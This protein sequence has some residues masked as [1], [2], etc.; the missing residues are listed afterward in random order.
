MKKVLIGL[1]VSILLLP[2]LTGCWSKTEL[3]DL[4][5][6]VA[7]G[8]DKNEKG[9]FVVSV[10]IINPSETVTSQNA[11]GG[12]DT[13]VTTYTS[14]GKILF[15]ALRRLSKEVPRKIYLAHLR[16]VVI[17]EEVAKS[18]LYD[19]LDF[20]SRT[21][22]L[23]TDFYL[24]VA[25]EQTA[26]DTLQI[27][28]SIEK[29]PANKLFFSLEKSAEVWAAT[30]KVTLNDLMDDI[31]SEGIQPT[32][33]GVTVKGDPKIGF[34][35]SNVETISP[36][37]LYSYKGIAAFRK[38]KLVG[39][40]NEDESK[41]LN[42]IK[43]QVT[44][45]VVVFDMNNDHAGVE[46]IRTKTEIIPQIKNEDISIEVKVTGEAN[47]GEVNTKLD[48]MDPHIIG[49]LESLVNRDIRNSI[50][51]TVEKAQ[52]DFE[53]DILG[54]GER[55]HKTYPKDW[56][57]IKKQWKEIFT[58]VPVNVNVKIKIRRIGTITNP[59]HDELTKE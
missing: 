39:W 22:E 26:E 4:A 9:D 27:L 20:L 43:D 24:V 32:L 19:A 45:T 56:E 42:Y 13:P 10:Q 55:I 21:H 59:F 37:A 46:L 11:G 35:K 15:E 3:T 33:T 16:M 2:S 14:T 12:Y 44:S 38:N 18:G 53:S 7:L 51:N 52:K 17:G 57:K 54:F 41:G 36:N 58:N 30:G 28:T 23:R 5:I 31:V 34:S 8:I 40:L 48:L 1:V 49:E 29:I 50:E 6:A 47:V 25:K